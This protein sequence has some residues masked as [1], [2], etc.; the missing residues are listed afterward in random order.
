MS[1][2]PVVG[3]DPTI[4]WTLRIFLAAVFARALLAKLR[5]PGEFA[6]AVAGYE[7]LP[8]LLSAP[9]AAA[10]LAAEL[11]VV[12]GLLVA[13]V[14]RAACLAAAG[15][16]LLYTAAIGVNL[17]R[18]R[19]DID[20]GCAGPRERRSLHELLVARNLLYSS[21]AALAAATPVLR[22]WIWLDLVTIGLALVVLVALAIA[23]DGMAA[24]AA[25]FERRGASA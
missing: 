5:A 8:R 22:S 16:L 20:C 23:L 21:M 4:V 11:A 10:L 3:L 1:C 25:P 12:V 9:I 2:V 7:L 24:F 17:A 13:P 6:A 18:G 15:L 19:R 14:G